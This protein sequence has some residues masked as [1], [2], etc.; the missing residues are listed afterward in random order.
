MTLINPSPQRR[1][2][3]AAVP[4]LR[5]ITPTRSAELLDRGDLLHLYHSVVTMLAGD[6][7][8]ILEITSAVHGEGVST[9]ASELAAVVAGDLGQSVLLIAAA[10]E[11]SAPEGLEAVAG[12][13]LP[14]ERAVDPDRRIPFLYR[15]RLSTG[16][17]NAGLLFNNS[18]LDRLFAQALRFAQF[19]IVDAP[20]VLADVTGVALARHV[21]GVL[22]VIEAEKTRASMVEKAR[23]SIEAAEGR[24]CGVVLNKRRQRIPRAIE[25]RF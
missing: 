1:R 25:R 5:S 7:P 2:V 9:V 13:A 23:R 14:F 18:D 22:L 4:P 10:C 11:D 15:A 21:G 6:R 16:G 19:V 24:I 12:S 3:P 20:P 17:G 8:N